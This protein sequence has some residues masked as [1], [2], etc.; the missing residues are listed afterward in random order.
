MEKD[1]FDKERRVNKQAIYSVFLISC[2][3]RFVVETYMS[4]K[5]IAGA[6]QEPSYCKEQVGRQTEFRFVALLVT[7][8][9]RKKP[10]LL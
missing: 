5:V 4:K 3:M 6:I 9:I 1:S 8:S 10:Y 7:Q 2:K